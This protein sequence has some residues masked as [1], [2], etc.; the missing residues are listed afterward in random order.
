MLKFGDLKL[1]KDYSM[2]DFGTVQLWSS[3]KKIE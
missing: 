1:K 2:L 3:I